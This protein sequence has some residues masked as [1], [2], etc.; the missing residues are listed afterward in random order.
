MIKILQHNYLHFQLH[1]ESSFNLPTLR[2]EVN[3][4]VEP[5]C[6]VQWRKKQAERIAMKDKE[7]EEKM[8]EMREKAKKDLDDWYSP[9][10]DKNNFIHFKV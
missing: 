9:H 5:D 2:K 1:D 10:L 8:R 7:E 6:I 4:G 3:D